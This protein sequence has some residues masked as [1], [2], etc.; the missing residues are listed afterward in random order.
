MLPDLTRTYSGAGVLIA[1]PNNSLREQV[2]HSF[3]DQSCTV[4][5]ATGGAEALVKL[6]NG[7]WQVL[8]LDRRLP[9]LD[10]EELLQI[11]RKRFPGIEVVLLDSDS[12]EPWSRSAKPR[13]GLGAD[14][15]RAGLH[16]VT[17]QP[18]NPAP[19]AIPGMI[20]SSQAMQRVYRMARLVAGRTTTVLILGASGTGKELVARGIH[21]LSPRSARPFV[22][23]NCAAIPESLLESELFGYVR[24]AFTGAVQAQIGRIQA[25]QG[26]TLFL[27]E[28]GEL[29]LSM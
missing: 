4:Q 9:D 17:T 2:L 7:D 13:P 1:S 27:D 3:Q 21:Q 25:A 24:G 20:G 10:A 14:T 22:V 15:I 12:R 11:I 5:Q 8:F 16:D 19:A 29:P 28:I 23:V 18:P 26:G 6:E